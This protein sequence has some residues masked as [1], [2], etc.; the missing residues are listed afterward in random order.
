MQ[1]IRPGRWAWLAAWAGLMM[2]APA[3]ATIYTWT[4][5]QGVRHYSDTSR[6]G[7]KPAQLAQAPI[8]SASPSP[9]SGSSRSGGPPRGDAR[10]LD[11]ISPQQGQVFASGPGQ[12]PVS[13]IVGSNDD[14]SGLADGESLRYELDGGSIGPGPTQNTRL[15]LSNLAAGSHTFSVT[16]LYRGHAVQRSDTVTF[17]VERG[18]NSTPAQPPPAT[19]DG[20]PP[21]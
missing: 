15:T 6:P 12:V 9:A 21:S 10:A 3:Q 14:K 11:V 17:R 1:T 18:S 7:A 4:D 5:A 2:A 13:V 8:S 16:L 19:A 20:R